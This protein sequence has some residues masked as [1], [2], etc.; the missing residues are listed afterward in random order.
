MRI[1]FVT[2]LHIG[3]E[4]EDTYGIDVR[5][6][7]LAVLTAAMASAP[8][9][10]VLGGD[11]CYSHGDE[12]IYPWIK[13]QL[14]NCGIAYHFISGNHD[15]PAMMANAL[16][17]KSAIKEGQLYYCAAMGAHQAI[18][19][20]TTNG[21]IDRNQLVWLKNQLDQAS[22]EVLIFM[23][24]PPV[25]AGVP[26]MDNNYPLINHDEILHLL[27]ELAKPVYV[28]CGHYHVE[29][30]ISKKQVSVFI[31]PSCFFQIGQSAPQFEVD[32]YRPG[33]RLID[34]T[35]GELKTTVRYTE[36]FTTSRK[37]DK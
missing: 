37:T 31:T 18:F 11:L 8:D 30:T 4:G 16:G 25:L 26:F 13:A 15:N 19:L 36:G 14:D 10:L 5:K 33:W 22:Q 1:A 24:H 28:F 7:F 3:L 20:D 32:H 17:R 9:Y 35:P 34:I 29:K 21:H 6:N 12:A 27:T 23:H 2:D